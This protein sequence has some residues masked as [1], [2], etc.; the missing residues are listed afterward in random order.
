MAV[1]ALSAAYSIVVAST[2]WDW[3]PTPG[4]WGDIARIPRSLK[5]YL[6]LLLPPCTV[7]AY[8]VIRRMCFGATNRDNEPGS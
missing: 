7:L 6:A 3:F 1:I 4:E 8:L 5:N 2:S